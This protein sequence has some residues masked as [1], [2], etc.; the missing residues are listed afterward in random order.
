MYDRIQGGDF[1]HG[2][3]TGGES[4][5]GQ[6]FRDED[7]SIPHHGPGT[8]S[9]ANAGPNTNG[10]QFFICTG[11]TPWLDGR[12]VVFGHVLDGMEIVE[13]IE[14]CGQRSGTPNASVSILDCGIY[15]QNENESKLERPSKEELKERLQALREIEQRFEEQKKEIDSDMYQQVMKEIKHEKKRIKKELHT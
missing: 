1:T 10:S 6:R 2:N 12:H 11:E 8:L 9:M 15:D 5:Y 13:M 3:G 4:I 14:S 7:L